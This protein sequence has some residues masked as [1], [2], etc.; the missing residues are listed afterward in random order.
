MQLQL[1]DEENAAF[2]SDALPTSLDLAAGAAALRF[3][4]RRRRRGKAGTGGEPGTG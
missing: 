4:T 1:F 2:D 3:G